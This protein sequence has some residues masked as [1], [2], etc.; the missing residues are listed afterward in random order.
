VPN[1]LPPWPCFK[2]I[3]SFLVYVFW[4]LSGL[5]KKKVNGLVIDFEVGFKEYES[6]H[7][8]LRAPNCG[9]NNVWLE[10]FRY[11][12]ICQGTSNTRQRR[13]VLL[14][15]VLTN[16]FRGMGALRNY[17]ETQQ[18]GHPQGQDQRLKMKV[19]PKMALWRGSNAGQSR[20][21]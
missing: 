21:R 13:D 8:I 12:F 16:P 17:M 1:G 6:N 18:Q 10:R 19:V 20:R 15:V 7:R 2:E 3:E 5:K 9:R 14:V 4:G 11:S